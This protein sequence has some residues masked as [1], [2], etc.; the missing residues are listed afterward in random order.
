MKKA[1]ILTIIWSV[2]LLTAAAAQEIKV[3]IMHF[4]PF[5]EYQEGQE[6]GGSYLEMLQTILNKAEV[7]YTTKG[8]PAKRLYSNLSKGTVDLFLG[9]KGVPIYDK[10][11]IYSKTPKGT[12][13]IRIYA[14]GE[15]PLPSGIKDLH[16]KKVTVI[17]GYAYGGMI[18]M[19][20]D[21]ASNIVLDPTRTHLSAFKKLKVKRCDYILDYGKPSDNVLKTL[22]FPG[23]QW[24][25]MKKL[26]LYFIISK[27][28][29]NGQALMEKMEKVY[30]ELM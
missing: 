6:L 5:Y 8:Y 25:S 21:P 19:L 2:C 4:P 26:D 22:D 16:G 9:I 10:Q 27:Q 11:V 20:K 7:N 1:L 30:Q 23:I 15:S 24:T 18:T 14:R 28:T 17:A 12:I 29:Q 13:D 3:G